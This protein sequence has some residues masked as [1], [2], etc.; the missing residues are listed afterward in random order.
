MTINGWQVLLGGLMLLPFTLYFEG[1]HTQYDFRF[2]MSL[3]WLVIPVSIGA[4][5]LWLYLLKED[6]VRASLWLFLCP[7][8]GLMF[9]SIL[10]S[11][12]FTLYTA[13][14]ALL[15][16]LSLFWGQKKAT[17]PK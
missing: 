15:V 10:L 6:T 14:G 3:A 1:E 9:S 13:L 11:E 12:P 4:I 2:W 7:I 8:F 5:Q 17:A 16:I